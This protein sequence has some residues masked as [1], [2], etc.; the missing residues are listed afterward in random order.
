MELLLF[1]ATQN[2]DSSQAGEDG[3]WDES[4]KCPSQRS[5]NRLSEK[6]SL[7]VLYLNFLRQPLTLEQSVFKFSNSPLSWFFV[8]KKLSF[9]PPSK[10]YKIVFTRAMQFDVI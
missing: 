3:Q 6:P 4:E 7:A 10:Y 5:F 1:I 9:Y 2:D 8:S